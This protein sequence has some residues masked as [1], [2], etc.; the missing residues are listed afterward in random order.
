MTPNELERALWSTVEHYYAAVGHHR[1]DVDKLAT[2]TMDFE[3]EL[4]QLITQPNTYTVDNLD[5]I[6]SCKDTIAR[7]KQANA[8]EH[9]TTHS[10]KTLE[11]VNR[12]LDVVGGI[13]QEKQD[14]LRAQKAVIDR[15]KQAG[16]AAKDLLRAAKQEEK[17]G[18][19]EMRSMAMP[20][21]SLPKTLDVIIDKMLA[22]PA[23]AKKPDWMNALQDTALRTAVTDRIIARSREKAGSATAL[24]LPNVLES[25]NMLIKW[26]KTPTGR[27]GSLFEYF[28]GHTTSY[29]KLNTEAI[30]QQEQHGAAAA[31]KPK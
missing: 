4:M 20:Q 8:P 29:Q 6:D 10:R 30:R 31:S 18:Q 11:V 21:L 2:I 1:G 13:L 7:L 23:T 24:S 14:K 22:M 5:Q 25:P 12:T 3:A 26:L 17:K 27:L 28:D 16:A 19:I 15:V 9:R